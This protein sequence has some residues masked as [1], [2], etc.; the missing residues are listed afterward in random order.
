MPRCTQCGKVNREGAL[1]CQ[2]CGARIATES[3]V[4]KTRVASPSDRVAP[5]V[6][7]AAPAQGSGMVTCPACGVA[8]PTGINF[9]KM[10]GGRLGGP[11]SSPV[12]PPP[13]PGGRPRTP[14]APPGG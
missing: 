3:D 10:C 9:C 4:P 13:P 5:A 6:P 14:P 7:A 1:F 2:D 11:G 12:A 8:N